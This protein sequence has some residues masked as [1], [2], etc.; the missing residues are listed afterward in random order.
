MKKTFPAL[1]SG[2]FYIQVV[3][4]SAL[5]L[6][7]SC[8]KISDI[9][10]NYGIST[11]QRKERKLSS[12]EVER[13]KR[14]LKISEG[15]VQDLHKN[16]HG[17]VQET[18]LQGMLSW[19]IAKA[20]MDDA[21]YDMAAQYFEGAINNDMP[22]ESMMNRDRL[23]EES[24][25][26]FKKALKMHR[27]EPELL[28][29]AGL[30]FANASKSQ[31]WEAERFRTAVL[32]FTRMSEIKPDD[33]RPAYQLALLYAFTTKSEFRDQDRALELLRWVIKKEDTNISS[34][35]AVGHI[36]ALRGDFES[37]RSEYVR[38]SEIIKDLHASGILPGTAERNQKYIQAM[39]N[40]EKLDDCINDRPSCDIMK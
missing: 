20:Y 36:L 22:D 31:G 29:D 27:P 15:R 10:R 28:F 21:R 16:I 37:A 26:Y 4:I 13:W 25:V 18:N 38:I 2:R 5:I 23:F 17:M 35:F 39:E 24:L 11:K 7:V 34:R 33:I 12:E 1:F 30:C 3:L 8:E 32:L 6:P 40:I 9:L 19:R 14:D